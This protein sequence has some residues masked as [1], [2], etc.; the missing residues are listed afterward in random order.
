MKII[1]PGSPILLADDDADLA[2]LVG[3]AFK[4]L[5]VPVSLSWVADGEEAV[6]Y[7][8]GEARYADRLAFPFPHLVLLDLRLPKMNGF[9]VLRWIR[10]RSRT[11]RLPVVVLAGST[12]ETDI[13]YAYSLGANSFVSK[14]ENFHDLL[15]QL[16]QIADYWL[17]LA[18][19]P[20]DPERLAA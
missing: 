2:E 15:E 5:G 1:A 18:V 8:K 10:N 7:L 11:P 20:S 12:R 6:L 3:I 16:R 19:L 14:P 9:R 13:S 17:D 4:K